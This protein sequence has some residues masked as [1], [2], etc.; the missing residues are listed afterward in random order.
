MAT[1]PS[2]ADLVARGTA[3]HLA[4]DYERAVQDLQLAYRRTLDD[5][6]PA[7]AFAVAFS[8]AMVYGTTC[9]PA[10]FNGWAGRAERL[11]GELVEAPTER[12]YLAFLQMHGAILTGDFPAAAQLAPQVVAIGRSQHEED[13]VVLGEVA[14]GRAAIYSG[15]VRGGLNL[16]DEAMAGILAGETG[17]LATGLAWCAAVEGCQEI[18]AIDRLCEWTAALVTWCGSTPGLE[19]FTGHCSVH[20]GQVLTLQGHWGEAL[21]ALDDSRRRHQ[22]RGDLG[23][24]GWAERSRGDVLRL[25]GQAD[26]AAAAYRTAADLGCDPQPGL[27]LLWLA[28]GRAEAA[29]AAVRRCLA[30]TPLPAHRVA[31]LP[32]AVEV[33]VRAGTAG[34]SVEEVAGLA[35]ELDELATLTEC[36]SV[37]AA[38]AYAHAGVE[39]ARGDAAGA[40]P[41]AHKAVH[42]WGGVGCPFEQA[43]SRALRARALARVGDVD[44]AADELAAARETFVRLGAA[45]ADAEAGTQW[46]EMSGAALGGVVPPERVT[47]APDGL[48][49]REL[50][51]LALVAAGH[52]NRQ[53]AAE[54]VISE[55]T[56]A[57]HLSNIFTKIDVG[58]RTAAAAYAFQRGLAT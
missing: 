44:T 22:R 17:A 8:L 41:Y 7:R 33:L 20:R 34:D 19:L 6:D 58:S 31:L 56:V 36:A 25:R 47:E 14:L 9:Q 1:D 46:A 39:L 30:E 11:L 48:T 3:N 50:E 57:R 21:V 51:V 40:L 54:L 28:E 16:L 42:E 5:G 15:D 27:A 53:I 52:S 38:A 55:K 29:V 37:S 45:P 23:A 35:A 43:R 13:L 26:E 18:G 2:V 4:G 12:G 10:L 24:A 32:A 49:G